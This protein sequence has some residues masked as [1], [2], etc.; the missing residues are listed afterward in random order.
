MKDDSNSIHSCLRP[1]LLMAQCFGLL[2]L[3]GITGDTHDLKFTW[4]SWRIFHSFVVLGAIAFCDIACLLRTFE[5][6]IRMFKL[7]E[8]LII[9]VL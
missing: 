6:G 8:M 2:P 4:K 5:T 3:Q 9:T 7:G 1:I